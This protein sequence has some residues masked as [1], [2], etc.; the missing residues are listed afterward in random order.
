MD[1]L[2]DENTVYTLVEYR[3]IPVRRYGVR[4]SARSI[5]R[6]RARTR[7]CAKTRIPCSD[8]EV[9]NRKREEVKTP[10]DARVR[11]VRVVWCPHTHT[12]KMCGSRAMILVKEK[13]ERRRRSYRRGFGSF[14]GEYTR[15]T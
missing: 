5:L 3:N 10:T 6:T 2:Y 15:D 12:K 13:G 7:R 14:L 4:F 8:T 11:R 9:R 1:Y